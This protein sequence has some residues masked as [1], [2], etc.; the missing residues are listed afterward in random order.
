MLGRPS[1][2]C[3]ATEQERA[4]VTVPSE[5]P[6]ARR[7]GDRDE[8]ARQQHLAA[9]DQIPAPARGE[10]ET[11]VGVSQNGEPRERGRH[12]LRRQCDHGD[13][14]RA[15]RRAGR[16]DRSTGQTP[17]PRD[18]GDAHAGVDHNDSGRPRAR[19]S[20]RAARAGK[21]ARAL[22]RAGRRWRGAA[23]GG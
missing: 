21:P 12:R 8:I 4:L 11:A 20:G 5:A 18:A 9:G 14:P 19:A 1:A 15:A 7:F 10:R 6:D 2:A 16:Q 22:T 3:A 13:A 23:R 17:R